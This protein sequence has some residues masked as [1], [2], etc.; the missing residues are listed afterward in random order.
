MKRRALVSVSNKEGI[1]PFAKALVEHEVE[2]VSTGGTKRALQE[3]GIPVTGISDVTGFPEILDGRVKTLHPNIHGGLL[4]MRE[5]DEHL[6]Q[7]NEH[8]IRPIDFVVV[9]L[10]PFQ[11]TIAKPEATFADAIENIDIGG[12]SMLRAAAKNHQHVTVVVDPVDYETVLKELADQGNVATETK[13][14]L[15]AK[16]FRHTAA[17]DA[18]IAE[19]LTD[20]VGEESPESLTVT[21]E[22][23]QDLRYGEN[24]HQKAT[25]YQKPLGAKASIAHAKQ[26]HGKEL[27][28]NNIN[29][30]D[31][32]L[33]IVKEFKE[34]AAV[35]VKHMNP[36]GVGT[37]E[38]IKEAFDKAYEADP[39]SIFGGII[40]LNRE[41]DVETAKTLKEIFLEIIIAPSFSEEALDVLTS[42][43][44]LRL[45]T[46][47]LNEENQA[48]KRITSIHGGALVQEEDTYGFEEAEIKIPTKREPTEA[49]WE[50]LKLAWRVVKHVKS[51]AIV[52]AD[53]QMTVGVGAGQMNRVGAAKIA[54]EQA[55][56]KAAGS[57][58]G[59]DAFFPM[60][61]T[62]E[63]AAKAGITAIIQPGGSIRDEESIENADKHGIAMV[64]TG[65]RHFKH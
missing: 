35:A 24:P 55:G 40:A 53:G 36:C 60:G 44:N 37:G 64:F 27:S 16:V 58:M 54:I 28:Y 61:D 33:S 29:D 32:A 12:P 7:L 17:Y 30:A 50:A 13:R 1:V 34:P 21:F 62:V 10:Y 23:K 22:K 51:N 11:Q 38:T 26:L 2:I 18:M 48:E 47:P 57:V 43:K 56:E 9:N 15:A 42:K 6:A 41:V 49:E 20:A 31:A 14:R 19:Y 63:L 52:L 4:A 25:F 46:L 5:R 45:L 3:A 39:V 8:H 65:V 59:S